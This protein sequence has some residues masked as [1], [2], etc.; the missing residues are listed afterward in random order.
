MSNLK[1]AFGKFS[2]KEEQKSAINGGA[3]GHWCRRTKYT[4]N[5]NA[6]MIRDVYLHKDSGTAEPDQPLGDRG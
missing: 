1:E 2:L 5:P 4:S 3:D 6:W